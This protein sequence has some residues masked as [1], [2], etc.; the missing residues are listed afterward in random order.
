MSDI[1]L[2]NKEG[3]MNNRYFQVVLFLL[4]C[5]TGTFAVPAFLGAQGAGAAAV[6]GR[7]GE[8]IEVTNL[9]DAGPG[10]LRAAVDAS[11]AR[12]VVF[13]VAG[14]II[15]QSRLTIRNP[16]ITI[17][18]QTSPGGIQILAAKPEEGGP[19][20]D[21]LINVV[22][23]DVVIRFLRLR[24][25][26]TDPVDGNQNGHPIA[27][28]SG[29][30][31]TI[32]DHCSIYWTQDENFAIW[33]TGNPVHDI[34]CSWNI[35]T[36]PLAGHPTNFA[37]GAS[38]SDLIGQQTDLD[39][40]HNFVGTSSHRNPN[41][42]VGTSRWINNVVYNYGFRATQ[43]GGRSTVDIISNIYKLGPLSG[44]VQS[45]R[46]ILWREEGHHPG[47]PSFYV[48]GNKGPNHTDFTDTGTEWDNMVG[49][50]YGENGGD[51]S[52]LDTRYRRQDPLSPAGIAITAEPVS[53]LEASLGLTDEPSSLPVG[54]ARYLD[55]NGTWVDA[56][57]SN[58]RRVIQEYM[59]NTGPSS[60]PEDGTPS[61]I[62]QGIP[63]TDSDHDGM[64]DAW[65]TTHGLNPDDAS[66]GNEDAD[67]DGFTNVEQFLNGPTGSTDMK[68]IF[69]DNDAVPRLSVITNPSSAGNGI[70][71]SYDLPAAP[72]YVNI[73]SMEGRLVRCLAVNKAGTGKL[74]WNGKTASGREVPT[75]VYLARL[76]SRGVSLFRKV[77]MLP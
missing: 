73:Y 8:I 33:T 31:T 44:G 3:H 13:R 37:V 51:E 75:G 63:Y 47:D 20:N 32:V 24:H 34:T 29:A 42:S 5:V 50:A 76:A 64:P 55:E 15:L 77:T 71:F 11:G 26:K 72:A 70:A 48:S 62:T 39:F 58:D 56:Y 19:N 6:G 14:T 25:G 74:E 36:E 9:N 43:I 18:G 57:D 65:E 12:I 4:L 10:S 35:I 2:I 30:Y 61:V 28:I 52:A 66:D 45:L 53:I 60:L 16:Y 22:T 54:A 68:T 46:E 69:P 59:T 67:G 41:M 17:A 38:S 7:G 23:H 21:P 40:H 49:L 27:L 1:H